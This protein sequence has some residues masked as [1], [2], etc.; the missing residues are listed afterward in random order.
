MTDDILD[1]YF[2][3]LQLSESV[4]VETDLRPL[5]QLTRRRIAQQV[6]VS[7]TQC[8]PR[9]HELSIGGL[10]LYN[11]AINFLEIVRTPTKFYKWMG[12]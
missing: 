7:K 8:R 5:V 2:N 6:A 11:L 9:M 10:Q 12:G 4:V 1:E 3:E